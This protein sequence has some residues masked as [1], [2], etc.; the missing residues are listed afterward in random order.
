[1]VTFNGNG[2]QTLRATISN[3]CGQ[4][5]AKSYVINTG[6]PTFASSAV[7]SGNSTFCSGSNLYTISGVLPGQTVAWSLSDTTIASLSGSTNTQTTVNF[8]GSGA[9]TLTATITNSCGQTATK[10]FQSYGGVPTLTS[11]SCGSGSSFCSGTVCV[12]DSCLPSLDLSSFVI[13]NMVGQTTTESNLASNWQ[14]QRLNN[15]I[16]L[17][18]NRNRCYIAANLLGET[19]VQVRARNSCGWSQWYTLNFGVVSCQNYFSRTSNVY[20]V[21]PNPSKDIVKI[22]LRDQHH[23]PEKGATISGELFDILGISK[24]KVQIVDNKATFSVQGLKKGICVLK[25]YINDKVETHQIAV[26]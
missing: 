6:S 16:V 19:G 13:A 25:I 10:S 26:E 17:Q 18:P 12:C 20:S 2:A 24:S 9:Q 1:M 14:W 22:D 15:N 7:I 11:F 5:V 21:F 8:T 23:H 4:T 3:V